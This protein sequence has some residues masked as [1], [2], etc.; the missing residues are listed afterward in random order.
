MNMESISKLTLQG[1]FDNL[2]QT[3][4]ARGD[5][6]AEDSLL[7]LESQSL[8]NLLELLIKAVAIIEDVHQ[9]GSNLLGTDQTN[10]YGEMIAALNAHGISYKGLPQILEVENSLAFKMPKKKPMQ[11]AIKSLKGISRQGRKTG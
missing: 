4:I 2:K 9:V 8:N 10:D 5:I 11:K 3:L 7:S 6:K 1:H